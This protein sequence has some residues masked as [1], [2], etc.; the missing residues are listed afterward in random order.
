[1]SQMIRN[2]ILSHGHAS[3]WLL[4]VAGL[5][6]IMMIRAFRRDRAEG[7]LLP[8]RRFWVVTVIIAG[9]WYWS[10][11]TYPPA[12]H[13]ADKPLLYADMVIIS[14][15]ISSLFTGGAKVSR[16]RDSGRGISAGGR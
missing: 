7:S 14:A 10:M 1:M 4:P 9:L 3:V 16:R 5:V 15:I 8:P 11:R 12:E 13:S 6:L 2:F